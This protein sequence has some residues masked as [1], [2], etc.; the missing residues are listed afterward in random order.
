MKRTLHRW[1]GETQ[2]GESRIEYPGPE[3]SEAPPST[4][5][6]TIQG[7]DDLEMRRISTARF[8]NALVL[9]FGLVVAM[10]PSALAGSGGASDPSDAGKPALGKVL[11]ELRRLEADR[12]REDQQI[13]VM[14]IERA[15]DEK[16]IKVLESEVKQ[17]EGQNQ[18]LETANQ[19]LQGQ[20]QELQTKVASVPTSSQFARAL[21]GYSGTHQFT[22]A[23]GAAG[24]FIYDRRT[25]T[26]TFAL[27]VEPILLYH[28]ND[29]LAFEA[30]IKASFSPG[31]PGTL[32][33][34]ASFDMPV[35]T[36]QIFLNDYMELVTGIFDQ[37]FGDF[38]ETQG[39]FWVNRMITAPLPFG[40]EALI[41]PT[42]LGAQLRGGLQWGKLGQD[43]DYTAWI[44]NGP[45]FTLFPQAVVGNLVAGVNNI[46]INTHGK[47]FGGRIRVYPLPVDS[48]FGRLEV[49][50]STYDG[51]YQDGMWL[52][53]WG[54]DFA[55]HRGDLQTRGEFLETYRQMGKMGFPANTADNRQGWYVQA[56]YF[57]T[58]VHPDFLGPM[59][60]KYL[61]RLE[62]IVRYSGV[63]Q[64]GIVVD[65]VLMIP[66]LG[67]NGSPSIFTPHARE[68]ALG[69]DYWIAPSIVW[70]TEF[71]MELPR[72]GGLIIDPSNSK[73]SGAGATPNDRAILTQLAIGF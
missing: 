45:S 34:G 61:T 52:N 36:A 49:G 46:S 12:T 55:Y 10:P 33:S 51:K 65:D 40:S 48:K 6:S 1:Q 24:S 9:L 35:A 54:V 58:G 47:A 7:E 26:N 17:V 67:S 28:V 57:L 15:Q 43:V 64:R 4:S 39:P 20:T 23:G 3:F 42:D 71:D 29:W 37:P 68:V 22:L 11:R 30:T 66:A 8:G 25:N 73:V 5:A 31:G 63:N 19:Q 44:S 21:E 14:Q 62:P 69:L 72:A 18:K 59:L 41:T 32:G 60:N 38:Y 56:G 70:Q 2:H 50:A 27:Q 16:E 53:S 13:K